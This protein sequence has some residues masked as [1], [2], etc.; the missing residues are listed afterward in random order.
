[1]SIQAAGLV[2]LSASLLNVTAP[3]ANFSGIVNAPVVHAQ[4]ISGTAY[5]PGLGNIL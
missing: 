2:N 1:M 3:V 5:T 4:V